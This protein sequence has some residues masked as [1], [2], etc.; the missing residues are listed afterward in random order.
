MSV[1]E[2]ILQ[3]LAAAIKS[4]T[5]YPPDHPSRSNPL[6]NAF[7]LISQQLIRSELEVAIRE[8]VLTMAGEPFFETG[9]AL[10]ELENRMREREIQVFRFQPGLV[11]EEL[12]VF[13]ELM[14]ASSEELLNYSGAVSYLEKRR[15]GHIEIEQEEDDVPRRSIKVYDEAKSFIVNLWAEARTGNM[16]RGEAAVTIVNDMSK[17]L[18]QDRSP[19][20]GLTMLSDYDNYTFNHSVNVGVFAMALAKELR[21]DRDAIR[22]IG[23]AGL[24]HDVGKTQIS[25]NIINKPGKLDPE[26]WAQMK[27]HP[28]Y[29]G[30]LVADMGLTHIVDQV[31]QHH[32]GFDRQGY[33][34]LPDGKALHEVAMITA[35]AD[36]YDSMT[37][38]R[39]YQRCHTPQEAIDV[40]VRLR[41]NGHLNPEYV[42]TFLSTLGI[43][44]VGT[45]VRLDDGAVGFVNLVYRGEEN[46]PVVKLFRDPQGNPVDDREIIDLRQHPDR[47]IIGTLDPS[48]YGVRAADYVDPSPVIGG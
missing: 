18:D 21:Y 44:P 36:V 17:L 32:C 11:V 27:R 22:E 20:L 37:T 26:E 9:P 25:L 38:T 15:I 16:P 34:R 13:V 3:Q 41:N 12:A 42:Q 40:L 35:V 45:C 24:L 43:Y 8:E 46:F 39:P 14:S 19:L 5:L 31:R 33:P 10:T 30:E 1:H 23:L 29:S 47:Q 7:R 48:R 2:Q 28:E 4:V 6:N